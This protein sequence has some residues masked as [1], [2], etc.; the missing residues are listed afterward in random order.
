MRDQN[1][2]LE[3][4]FTGISR[5]RAA[6]VIAEYFGTQYR[7]EGGSYD[8]YSVPDSQ[9][10][11][12][13]LVSDAS[14]DEVSRDG[15]YADST[16][17]VELVTPICVYDDIPTIQEILRR[18]RGAHAVANDSCGVHIHVSAAPHTAQS[19]RNLTNIMASKEDMI[20][21][22]LKVHPDREHEYCKKMDNRFLDEINRKKPQTLEDVS[23]IWYNGETH[24]SRSHYDNSRYG[25]LNLHSVFQKGTVEFRLFNSDCLKHAGKAKAYIQ[26]CLALSHKALT[27]RSASPRKTV[28][29]NEKYTFRVFLL[30]L[31]LI[32][33]EFKT[34]RQ[35]LLGNL[36]GNIAWRDPAQAER[37]KERFAQQREQARQ[38]AAAPEPEP[39]QEPEYSA[40]ESTET[41]EMEMAGTEVV[42]QEDEQDFGLSMSM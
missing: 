6:E 18:L 14:I 35:H 26:F 15:G 37:Q 41:E 21:R 3:C 13:K 4:E 42:C 8:T 7:H 11:S 40:L 36:E 9:G 25:G 38:S 23:R 12:W 20:Y 29:P 22:A 1:F 16:Y 17:R 28:S 24:R 33:D 10:R 27:Q 19:L 5:Q 31:G 2:G 39:V 32:G 30:N 34:A